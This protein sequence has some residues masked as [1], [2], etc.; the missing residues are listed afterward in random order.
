MHITRF[1]LRHELLIQRDGDLWLCRLREPRPPLFEIGKQS[2][3]RDDKHGAV[4]LGKRAVHLPRLIGEYAQMHD[5][6]REMCGILRCILR[7][8]AE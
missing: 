6:L 8:Y 3:L 2:E 4:C 5:F 1:E 7:R